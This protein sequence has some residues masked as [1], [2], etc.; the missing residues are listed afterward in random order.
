MRLPLAATVAA[1]Q[2]NITVFPEA[3][4]EVSSTRRLRRSASRTAAIARSW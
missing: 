4:G 1:N 3:V 2:A